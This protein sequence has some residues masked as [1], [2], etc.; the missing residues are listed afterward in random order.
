MDSV[1]IAFIELVAGI[2]SQETLAVLRQG[3]AILGRWTT[4]IP[5]YQPF[6]LDIGIRD[7]EK[8]FFS[9]RWHDETSVDIFSQWN[10]ATCYFL[11]VT[12]TL[13]VE[14]FGKQFQ[15]MST[16][17]FNALKKMIARQRRRI[18]LFSIEDCTKEL[19]E[20]VGELLGVCGGPQRLF[21]SPRV[22]PFAPVV[23]QLLSKGGVCEFALYRKPC[24]VWLVPTLTA[25]LQAGILRVIDLNVD[26]SKAELYERLIDMAVSH[27][28]KKEHAYYF[29]SYPKKYAHLLRPLRSE[30][31]R[32]RALSHDAQGEKKV[33]VVYSPQSEYFSYKWRRQDP[34]FYF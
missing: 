1:P 22:T 28:I 29:L 30:M 32:S 23:K 8:L 15:P 20:N 14:R 17:H 31:N 6:Y 18:W 19:V 11:D 24:P 3:Q 7:G 27:I 33:K 34:L 21:I 16:E 5:A 10:F 13:D 25:Q 12:V 4:A 9:Q 2:V 26:E